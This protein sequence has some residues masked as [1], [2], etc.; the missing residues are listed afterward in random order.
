MQD[1][2]RF[3]TIKNYNLQSAKKYQLTF[4]PIAK[5]KTNKKKK[6]SPPSP[7]LPFPHSYFING[8]KDALNRSLMTQ[9]FENSP[10]PSQ[11]FY[12]QSIIQL[13][14]FLVFPENLIR[15]TPLFTLSLPGSLCTLWNPMGVQPFFI[16]SSSSHWYLCLSAFFPRCLFFQQKINRRDDWHWLSIKN[17]FFL[18]T[19]YSLT[20]PLQHFVYIL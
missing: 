14:S 17:G 6:P 15:R 10:L 2:C 4:C 8:F 9:G 16:F 3:R 5:K 19:L 20:D 12:L 18:L 1:R 7:P 11:N 13:I